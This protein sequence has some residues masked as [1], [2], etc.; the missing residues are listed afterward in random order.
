MRHFLANLAPYAIAA[1][2]VLGAA[3]FA[4][5]RSS[6]MVLSD[7]ATVLAQ[8]AP[9]EAHEFEWRALGAGSY[10]RNCAACHSRDGGGWD[11]YPGVGHTARLVAAPRGREYVIDLHLYGLA[12]PRWRV[13]MPPMG[14]MADVEL[15]AVLNH[16]LTN[17][18]NARELPPGAPLYLPADIAARRGL[19]LRPR[20]VDRFRPDP[21][22]ADAPD[23]EV[24]V[25]AMQ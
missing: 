4:S 1:L 12:S 20:E 2:I 14:H 21:V 13:P 10:V 19:R 24:Q 5:V 15:A 7:E 18:G 11:Q 8:F 22:P 6:Q 3:I 25:P 17:F 16:V 9:G 23:R